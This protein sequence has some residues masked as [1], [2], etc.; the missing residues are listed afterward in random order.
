MLFLFLFSSAL[1]AKDLEF[2][3]EITDF[4][5]PA[6]IDNEIT[7]QKTMKD[8]RIKGEYHENIDYEAICAKINCA[9]AEINMQIISKEVSKEAVDFLVHGNTICFKLPVMKDM[10]LVTIS[11]YLTDAGC[12]TDLY[13]KPTILDA[14]LENPYLR[15]NPNPPYKHD[16]IIKK[17][18]KF[19]DT[20]QGFLWVRGKAALTLSLVGKDGN[21]SGNLIHFDNYTENDD[22]H[23]YVYETLVT[24]GES[25]AFS[26]FTTQ[27]YPFHDFADASKKFY[28]SYGAL[29]ITGMIKQIAHSH[30]SNATKQKIISTSYIEELRCAKNGK[31][32]MIFGDVN[33]ESQ[34]FSLKKGKEEMKEHSFNDIGYQY[35]IYLSHDKSRAMY[36]GYLPSFSDPK[37]LEERYDKI[38]N[39][40]SKKFLPNM[41]KM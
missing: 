20:T 1:L 5:N 13:L 33:H 21:P 35:K 7:M 29:E 11:L 18:V 30:A 26:L 12:W 19:S 16:W 24:I 2:E 17:Q 41:K 27:L 23:D 25:N 36:F 8:L 39:K 10:R 37:Y 9:V 6:A 3:L 32:F 4:Y 22:G 40:I 14:A 15:K 38:N 34:V 31:L 28:L